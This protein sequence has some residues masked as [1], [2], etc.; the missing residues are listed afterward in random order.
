MQTLKEKLTEKAR[1]V[2]T[3]LLC[4]HNDIPVMIISESISDAIS[5][6]PQVVVDVMCSNCKREKTTHYTN[7]SARDIH[8]KYKIPMPD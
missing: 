5:G 1:R 8:E 7:W 3:Q 2:L 4:K 6:I